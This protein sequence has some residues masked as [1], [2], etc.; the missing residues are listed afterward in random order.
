MCEPCLPVTEREKERE[1]ETEREREKERGRE[2]ER[3]VCTC[4]REIAVYYHLY[5]AQ[6]ESAGCL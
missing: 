2:G 6:A 1:R 5:D 3:V 4:N